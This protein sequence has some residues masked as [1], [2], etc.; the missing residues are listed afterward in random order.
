MLCPELKIQ[1]N[2]SLEIGVKHVIPLQIFTPEGHL[3][4]KTFRSESDSLE[5]KSGTE[6]KDSNED[7]ASIAHNTQ[8]SSRTTNYC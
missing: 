8:K 5:E 6:D 2:F 4:N 7:V 3:V 1:H